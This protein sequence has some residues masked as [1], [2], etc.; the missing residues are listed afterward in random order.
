[1]LNPGKTRVVALPDAIEPD[2]KHELSNLY[3]GGNPKRAGKRLRAAAD[4]AFT[5]RHNDDGSRAITYLLTVLSN[6]AFHP[7]IW[8]LAQSIA[9]A[10]LEFEENSLPRAAKMFITAQGKGWAIDKPG[11]SDLLNRV[12]VRNSK[13]GHGQ[14]VAWALW[15]MIVL[16]FTVS[17]EAVGAVATAQDPIALIVL[18]HGKHTGAV[19]GFK[20]N[21]VAK[22]LG[23]PEC[24]N[25]EHW[26]FLY[27]CI[28]HNWVGPKTKKLLET[29][30]KTQPYLATL[31][32][33]K[34]SFYDTASGTITHA[35][36]KVHIVL[37]HPNA[38]AWAQIELPPD[39]T[40]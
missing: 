31:N 17:T 40:D 28:Q 1:V 13:L 6:C 36:G 32:K 5:K 24:W 14:L 29:T 9:L 39:Y 38:H 25:C 30:L 26:L 20:I 21:S 35:K 23:L 12:I 15:L 27:E 16:N 2:W 11:L 33:R 18:A 37:K 22:A 3:L 8:T 19:T 10:S 7:D 4:Y 34:V